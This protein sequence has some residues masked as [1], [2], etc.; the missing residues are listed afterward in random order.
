[1][2]VV[3]KSNEV[4]EIMR[5]PAGEPHVSVV[6][7]NLL[8]PESS[9]IWEAYSFDDLG[10]MM[11]AWRALRRLYGFSPKFVVPYFPFGRHDRRRDKWDSNPL[12]QAFDIV[13]P[14]LDR[15]D[16]I[17]ID[18]HSDVSGIIPHIGQREVV[19]AFI[20]ADAFS[21]SPTI[22]IPDK[23]ATAKTYGWIDLLGKSTPVVQGHKDRDPFT[24]QLTGFGV[25]PGVLTNRMHVAIVDDICD[26]G[27]T[28]LGLLEAIREDAD[29]GARLLVT[30]G[31]F[32][33]GIE[34][35]YKRFEL[36]TLDIYDKPE[37]GGKLKT[38]ST[39]TLV[40]QARLN[41]TIR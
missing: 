41:G 11:T 10:L 22:V 6:P 2:K 8:D 36:W 25:D 20:E 39:R 1:M 31:L 17:T 4:F 28:F 13:Q 30:H 5:Y 9:I 18:P 27:G 15:N 37:Y 3:Y 32:T 40:S 16:L 29:G 34:D 12:Q 35:L 19:Q 26:G 7:D 14:M 33:K 23:G 24:G 38:I 21:H